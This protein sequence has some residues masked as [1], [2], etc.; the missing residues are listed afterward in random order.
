[1]TDRICG[2]LS[3]WQ[4]DPALAA[5][6]S[7]RAQEQFLASMSPP[8][9]GQVD[10]RGRPGTLPR[11]GRTWSPDRLLPAVGVTGTVRGA[12]SWSAPTTPCRLDSP[13]AADPASTGPHLHFETR[14]GDSPVDP[15]TFYAAQGQVLG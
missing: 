12:D 14:A 8:R 4:Q 6:V 5:A 7:T 9:S 3:L 11:P 2:P 10:G 1:M 15:I 13:L